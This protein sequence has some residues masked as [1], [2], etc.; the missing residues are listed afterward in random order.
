MYNHPVAHFLYSM[1]LRLLLAA[2]LLVPAPC[3]AVLPYEAPYD[4]RATPL[5]ELAQELLTGNGYELGPDGKV[6]DKI[7]G[8]A[9]TR[10][11]MTY[12][13]SRLASSRR[14]R[15]LIELNIILNRSL[16]EKKLTI[17]EREAVRT[18][19]KKNW[20]VFSLGT[21]KDFRSYFSVEEHESLKQ[22]PVRFESA[23]ALMMRDPEIV[24]DALP[25]DR[26]PSPAPAGITPSIALAPT[27]APILDQAPAHV[28]QAPE[29]APARVPVPHRPMNVLPPLMEPLSLRR[30][31][32]FAPL[33]P[34][35]APPAPVVAAVVPT[36][37]PPVA[38]PPVAPAPAAA[39]PIVP[40]PT[41]VAAPPAVPVPTP[42]PVAA[43]APVA[44]APA[45]TAPAATA[46]APVY[47]V[48]APAVPTPL[49]TAPAP[50]PAAPAQPELGV[51]KPWTPPPAAPAPAPAAPAAREVSQEQLDSFIEAGPYS[52]E[53]KALLKL[54][55]AKAPD[56][57]RP[58]LR[59]VIVERTPLIVIDGS[60]TGYAWRAGLLPAD[61]T[62]N[63]APTIALSPGPVLVERKRGLFGR[64]I[65]VLGED[66]RVYAELGVAV[67]AAIVAARGQ[68]A[69][70]ENGPW[71][72]TKLYGAGVK[73]GAL[74]PQEQ[75][76]ELL[77]QLL[78]L[79]LEKEGPDASPYAAR[80]WARTARLLMTARLRDELA[81]D[82]FLDPERRAELRS[83]S[84]FPDEDGDMKAGSWS[85]ARGAALDA[86]RGAPG[87]QALFE[88]NAKL[89]CVRSTLAD[90]LVANARRRAAKV[91][92]IETLVEAGLVDEE[93]AAKA[94]AKAVS[95][96]SSAKINLMATP[97]PCDETLGAR[98][99]Q[100]ARAGTLVIEA[101]RAER[102]YRDAKA[103]G[104][105]H[106]PR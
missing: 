14:L 106:A 21:R 80:S 58:L 104:G 37:L 39:P 8:V 75:A 7:T 94:A 41:V 83:W 62:K 74:S 10:S 44:P 11:E 27:L 78:V 66:P 30:P 88:T 42:A 95:D 61:P 6:L 1:T 73:R 50:A 5:D 48:G 93:S 63:V 92:T 65:I 51:M 31:S 81:T 77:E 34:P 28:A 54:V 49:P 84:D 85:S 97:P 26:A 4:A 57:C 76:A 33:P 40:V 29:P 68:A 71:G 102:I 15:A 82:S 70:L 96:E 103:R 99:A 87:D 53:G 13:L 35:V 91:S 79:G 18:I 24:G 69:G 43:P 59:R 23:T 90:R 98:S 60:R 3:G 86:R 45:P 56:F 32:P 46:P 16:G 55:A 72:A 100:L 17:D 101:A 9:V 12:L 47:L 64:T 19:V 105:D 38:P 67:P 22:I 25:E 52:R 2:L 20:A 36:V 89:S